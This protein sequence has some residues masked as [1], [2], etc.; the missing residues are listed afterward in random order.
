MAFSIM[1]QVKPLTPMPSDFS[2]QGFD[3]GFFYGVGFLG[4]LGLDEIEW[5]ILDDHVSG[6]I[7]GKTLVRVLIVAPITRANA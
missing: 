6:A 2:T 4:P 1:S 7:N 3:L 5:G